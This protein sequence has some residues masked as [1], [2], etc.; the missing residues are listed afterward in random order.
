M[1]VKKIGRYLL[2]LVC[3]FQAQAQDIHWSQFNDNPIFQNPGNSGRF[4][5]DF[6]FHANYRDQWRSVTVPFSTLSLSAD[7]KFGKN[8]QFGLGGMLFHDQAGDGKFSTFEFQISPSILWKLTADSVHT[9]RPAI[10]FGINNR[11]VNVDKLSFD[12]QFNGFQ[13]DPSLPKNENLQNTGVTNFTI[14]WGTVYEWYQ[15][16]RKKVAAGLG[17]FN[18]NQPDNGFYNSKVKRDVRVNLFAKGQFK[19][20]FDWDILPSFQLNFQG[21][22]KEIIVGST[23]RYI[24]KDRLGEYRAV[25][26]GIFYRN[27][28]SGYLTA[29]MD[30][31]NWYAGISYDFNFSKLVPASRARGGIELS[32]R[33]TLFSLKPKKNIIHRVCPDYI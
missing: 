22:Y 9:L 14:S 33:Y 28:D 12:N 11:N 18:I 7:T 6:R 13:Y 5:G 19:I 26:G 10:Q 2:L 21:K 23:A 4:N 8:K 29:G 15:S 24:L 25:Y 27:K 30:Y 31:Q 1:N 20:D 32:L 17:I 3:A 16:P